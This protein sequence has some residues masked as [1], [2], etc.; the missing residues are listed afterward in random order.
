MNTGLVDACVLGRLLAQVISGQQGD[1]TL[2]RY[3]ALRR[4]AAGQV[5]HLA[6]RLTE[7]ATTRSAPKRFLRNLLFRGINLF[8]AARHRF[9]LNLSGLSRREAAEVGGCEISDAVIT[10][11]VDPLLEV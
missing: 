10:P 9:A 2:D 3:E 7:L 1:E 5:L 6:G 8:P 11:K 4:P